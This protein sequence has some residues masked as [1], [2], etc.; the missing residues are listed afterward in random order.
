MTQETYR[1]AYDEAN[2]E[3]KEILSKFE[4]LQLRREKIQQVVDALKPLLADGPMP[5]AGANASGDPAPFLVQQA[6]AVS[7]EPTPTAPAETFPEPVAEPEPAFAAE[8]S[9]PFQRRIDNALRHGLGARESRILPRALNGLLS[10][11]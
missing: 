8:S 9:D 5:E 10:R 3:L 6:S 11:A 4:E 7:S 2:S 1:L